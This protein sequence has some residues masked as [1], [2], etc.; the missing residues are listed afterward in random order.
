MCCRTVGEVRALGVPVPSAPSLP[1]L[2]LADWAIWL[3]RTA[4]GPQI[5]GYSHNLRWSRLVAK[6]PNTGVTKF[7]LDLSALS[8]PNLRVF[9]N[10][11]SILDHGLLLEF[12]FTQA[13]PKGPA[14]LAASLIISAEAAFS[15]LLEQSRDFYRM[16]GV[17]LR[18]AG[19]PV[20]EVEKTA[21]EW[22]GTPIV[23]CNLFRAS[24]SGTEA[25]MEC[26]WLS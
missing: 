1:Y 10:G 12:A 15:R 20:T 18:E 5:A 4:R 2:T 6:P 24:R 21:P 23:L 7:V 13:R 19:I 17:K 14:R 26:Y 3:A 22:N 9:A 25:S 16:E 11:C 8:A